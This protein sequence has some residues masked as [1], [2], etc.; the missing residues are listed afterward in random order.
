MYKE[1]LALSNL[2]WLMCHKIKPKSLS[3]LDSC[4]LINTRLDSSLLLFLTQRSSTYS[5]PLLPGPL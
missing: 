4:H 1:N 2:Q 5:L 3:H